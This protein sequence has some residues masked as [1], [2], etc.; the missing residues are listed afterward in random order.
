[1]CIYDALSWVPESLRRY[2]IVHYM[3]ARHVPNR[4]VT[5]RGDRRDQTRPWIPVI[6]SPGQYVR[7]RPG[8]NQT[9]QESLAS[10]LHG[11]ARRQSSITGRYGGECA[12]SSAQ[13]PT[14]SRSP[15]HGHQVHLDLHSPV[16]AEVE[17]SA[18]SSIPAGPGRALAVVCFDPNQTTRV[19]DQGQFNTYT[20]HMHAG[21]APPCSRTRLLSCAGAARGLR[22]AGHQVMQARMHPDRPARRAVVV[23]QINMTRR[24]R[25]GR[26]HSSVTCYS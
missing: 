18:R 1:M 10:T 7:A 20:G 3:H 16:R 6:G 15:M 14:G 8:K 21:Q 2:H 12:T 24:P 13:L 19:H 9:N 17:L 4:R 25:S 5:R 23:Q 11:L 22:P 26:R